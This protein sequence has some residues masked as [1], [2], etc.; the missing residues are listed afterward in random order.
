MHTYVRFNGWGLAVLP[1]GDF[2]AEISEDGSQ[3]DVGL[4]NG[5]FARLRVNGDGYKSQINAEA[6]SLNEVLAITTGEDDRRWW[7]ETS[8][9]RFVWPSLYRVCAR[10]AD[11]AISVVDL[12]GAAGELIFLQHPRHVPTLEDMAGP[13][14]HIVELDEA[15]ASVLLEY[16]F[17]G[18][19]WRQ[20]H[21]I[22]HLQNSTVVV[23]GQAPARFFGAFAQALETVA[24]SLAPTPVSP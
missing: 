11:A 13:G 20:R 1:Q 12:T 16:H 21:T 18:E 23:S 3:L 15:A 22:R 6:G 2:E 19:P 24:D 8:L 10:E 5:K 4:F 7:I 17:E 14:Q 9:Y